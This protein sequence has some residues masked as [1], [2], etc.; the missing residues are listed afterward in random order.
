MI[1]ENNFHCAEEDKI[2]DVNKLARG[3]QGILVVDDKASALDKVRQLGLS[4]KVMGYHLKL[5]DPQGNPAAFM[6]WL[7]NQVHS[8]S[9]GFRWLVDMD[10][11]LVDTNGTLFGPAAENLAQLL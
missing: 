5:D 3:C 6:S 10:G 1:N 11:V 7:E 8:M 2:T 9:S 4:M